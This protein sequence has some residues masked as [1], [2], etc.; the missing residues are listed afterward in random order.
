MSRKRELVS[1]D[2]SDII[3]PVT[4]KP[5][6]EEVP[7]PL[8]DLTDNILQHIVYKQYLDFDN[9]VDLIRIGSSRLSRTLSKLVGF[10]ISIRNDPK[11]SITRLRLA[12]HF[13]QFNLTSFELT[14]GSAIMSVGTFTWPSSLRSIKYSS[15]YM[16]HSETAFVYALHRFINSMAEAHLPNLEELTLTTNSSTMFICEPLVKLLSNVSGSLQSLKLQLCFGS[17]VILSNDSRLPLMKRLRSANISFLSRGAVGAV[18]EKELQYVKLEYQVPTMLRAILPDG[19]EFL[20]IMVN[21]VELNNLP[22]NLVRAIPR[23]VQ[24]L[25]LDKIGFYHLNDRELAEMCNELPTSLTKSDITDFTFQSNTWLMLHLLP[26]SVTD[27]AFQYFQSTDPSVIIPSDTT[28]PPNIRRITMTGIL[29]RHV[30]WLEEADLSHI[31]YLK[32]YSDSASRTQSLCF[33][34]ANL[35]FENLT[36]LS[37]ERHEYLLNDFASS[38]G[39]VY[40]ME[41]MFPSLKTMSFNL[42][43]DSPCKQILALLPVSITKLTI[44]A[45]ESF[46]ISLGHMVNLKSLIYR[47]EFAVKNISGSSSFMS[48]PKKSLT[49]VHFYGIGFKD[50]FVKKLYLELIQHLV[51][52]DCRVR[53]NDILDEED[54]ASDIT[55]VE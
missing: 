49:F 55:S 10:C 5:K 25:F 2:S 45:Q 18:V 29:K 44:H 31:E 28:L 8:A 36:E 3:G 17:V 26:T 34:S 21:R 46:P 30:S 23:S 50:D 22:I 16:M 20:R 52:V 24:S 41:N 32:L 48:L 38:G 47:D 6:L 54:S 1:S 51:K 53:V 42:S 27:F 40:A 19:L 9:W 15:K 14:A 4:K 12:V 33:F 37:C 13:E 7:F 39:E 35:R 43:Y 11:T